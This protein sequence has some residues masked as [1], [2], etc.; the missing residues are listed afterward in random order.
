MDLRRP[1]NFG[2][3]P[4][5]REQDIQRALFT[6]YRVRGAPGAFMFAVPNGGWRSPIEGAIFKGTGVV[7]GVPDIIAIHDGRCFALELKSEAGKLSAAQ[8][9]VLD[10]ME[11]AGA[12]V[13]V[14]QGLDAALRQLETWGLLRGSSI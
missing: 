10:L 8:R 4:A 3:P 14:A 13:A 5:I 2:K 9:H 12:T 1:R 6:H 11:R 7:A